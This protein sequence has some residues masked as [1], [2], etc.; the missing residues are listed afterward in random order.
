MN[1]A[2]KALSAATSA[3]LIASLL[4]TAA[5]PAALAN[6]SVANTV[7]VPV[8]CTSSGTALALT[9]NDATTLTSGLAGGGFC[10]VTAGGTHSATLTYTIKDSAGGSTLSF[11]GTPAFAPGLPGS[12]G[13]TVTLTQTVVANDSFTVK[14]TGCDPNNVEQFTVTGLQI[15]ATSLA[16][17]G[18]IKGTLT[19]NGFGFVTAVTGTTTK[20]IGTLQAAVVNGAAQTVSVN[21]TSTCPF[22]VGPSAPAT[23]ANFSD[24]SD[25]RS[26]VA[27]GAVSG[28]I[29]SVSFGAGLYG[30]AI[31]TTVTQTVG[32]CSTFSSPGTV[33]SVATQNAALQTSTQ[34]QVNPGQ[35]NQLAGTTTLTEPSAGF[36]AASSTVT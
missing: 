30:H 34:Q 4:A 32:A 36:L 25:A 13:A 35:Q 33:G 24:I 26:V 28:N 7:A 20:A 12:L 2:K 3:A 29:Q 19:D 16:A 21:V 10:T 6:T 17:T 9:F 1:L 15:H 23:T 18:T 8:W 22:V 11:T 27:V 14:I 31:T 5:V